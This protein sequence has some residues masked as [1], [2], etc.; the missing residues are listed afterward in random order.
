MKNKII[1]SFVIFILLL[2]SIVFANSYVQAL[3]REERLIEKQVQNNKAVEAA[4][5]NYSNLEERSIN[6]YNYCEQ[7]EE[8]PI[9]R[10]NGHCSRRN[11][12]CSQRNYGCRY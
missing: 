2:L 7:N 12:Y 10:D 8:C 1:I 3:S 9:Y 6:C 5:Y 4:N 11:N